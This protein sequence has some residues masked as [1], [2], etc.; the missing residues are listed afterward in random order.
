MEGENK[1]KIYKMLKWSDSEIIDELTR[2]CSPEDKF[3]Y[4]VLR[5]AVSR[6]LGKITDLSPPNNR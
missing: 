6:I 4:A 5:E 2:P 3:Q 1:D